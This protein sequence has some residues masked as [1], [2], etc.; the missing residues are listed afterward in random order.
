MISARYKCRIQCNHRQR[1]VEHVVPS[2]QRTCWVVSKVGV[3]RGAVRIRHILVQHCH[4]QLIVHG[5][6]EICVHL[7]PSR[8]PSV[9][10]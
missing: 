5:R 9:C 2:F 3:P 7:E 8:I 4:Q 1:I 10:R 6:T